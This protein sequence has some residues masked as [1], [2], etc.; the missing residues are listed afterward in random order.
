MALVSPEYWL[1]ANR[2]SSWNV[3]CISLFLFVSFMPLWNWLNAIETILDCHWNA[4]AMVTRYWHLCFRLFSLIKSSNDLHFQLIPH[5]MLSRNFANVVLGYKL[6]CHRNSTLMSL[7][8]CFYAT[9]PCFPMPLPRGQLG[10]G[11]GK[12]SHFKIKLVIQIHTHTHTLAKKCV[13]LTN[14]KSR[15]M[16]RALIG[17]CVDAFFF[18]FL[19]SFYFCLNRWIKAYSYRIILIQAMF[20]L[21]LLLTLLIFSG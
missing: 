11:R 17:R 20:Q 1:I 8:W 5:P 14:D 18:Y 16:R 3:Y 9:R 2:C 15:L 19:F 12:G 7:R 21:D 6:G 10:G 4:I 13:L